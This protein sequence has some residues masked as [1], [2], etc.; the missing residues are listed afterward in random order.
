MDYCWILLV[1]R[2]F[3]VHMP[4][5]RYSNLDQAQNEARRWL[6]ALFGWRPISKRV[7]SRADPRIRPIHA[8]LDRVAISPALERVPAVDRDRVERQVLS[9]HAHGTTRGRFRGRQQLGRKSPG[10]ER[11]HRPKKD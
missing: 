4:P 11:R 8:S 7:T 1:T 3:R 10:V 5:E 9:T 2:D 6:S